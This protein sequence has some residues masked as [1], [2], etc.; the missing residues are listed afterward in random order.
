MKPPLLIAFIAYSTLSNFASSQDLSGKWVGSA[1]QRNSLDWRVEVDIK[2]AGSSLA[3][4]SKFVI[5]NNQWVVQKFRGTI[6]GD[7]FTISHYEVT[8]F[9]AGDWC[10][11][12]FQGTCNRSQEINK[13][14]I[15]GTY[16]SLKLFD[17]QEYYNGDCPGGEFVFTKTLPDQQ[18][19]IST[20]LV[21]SGQIL[22]KHTLQPIKATIIIV[23][24]SY[25]KQTVT[26]HDD[27]NYSFKASANTTYSILISATNYESFQESSSLGSHNSIKNFL[28]FPKSA[29]DQKTDVPLFKHEDND[30][31][32]LKNVT[33]E[34]HLAKLLPESFPELD[35]LAHQMQDNGKLRIRLEGHTDKIVGSDPRLDLKL[36]TDRV[37][38]VKNYLIRKGVHS[39]RIE[40]KGYGQT[41][42]L[43][44][45]P[46][47]ANRRVEFVLLN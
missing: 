7:K 4:T 33:F 29:P 26:T 14:T 37:D 12:K 19:R 24:E 1:P 32:L 36:S 16:V 30:A 21:V 20:D 25:P 27:G 47:E 13:Y 9:S 3:G 2:Q 8:D 22:D 44:T 45:P 15:S 17:G 10:L 5:S 42:P 34:L 40:T 11:S 31:L 39:D 35:K 41:K 28:L 23:Y 46:N 38:A 18:K 6:K 43:F